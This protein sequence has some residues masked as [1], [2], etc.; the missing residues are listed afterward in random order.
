MASKLKK[1]IE[2]RDTLGE[3]QPKL[4]SVLAAGSNHRL[5]TGSMLNYK[6]V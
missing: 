2:I 1:T 6:L 3:V 4:A 5:R